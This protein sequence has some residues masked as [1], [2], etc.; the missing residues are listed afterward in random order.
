MMKYL[1]HVLSHT[2]PTIITLR[3]MPSENIVGKG[4]NTGY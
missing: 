1:R 4:E 3:K 2:V